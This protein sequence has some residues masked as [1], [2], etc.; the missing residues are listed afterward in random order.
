MAY[1]TIV[2]HSPYYILYT[3]FTKSESIGIFSKWIKTHD[4]I[5]STDENLISNGNDTMDSLNEALNNIDDANED[6]PDPDFEDSDMGDGDSDDNVEI[7]E[8][9]IADSNGCNCDS[10]GCKC[11][12]QLKIPKVKLKGEGAS[13]IMNMNNCTSK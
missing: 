6:L 4:L 12:Q 13:N 11:C 9:D 7:P 10:G 1:Q 5:S 2:L 8:V 3:I